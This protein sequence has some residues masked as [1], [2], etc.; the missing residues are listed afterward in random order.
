MACGFK[1][2]HRYETE[3]EHSFYVVYADAAQFRGLNRLLSMSR[4][5]AFRDMLVYKAAAA[6]RVLILVPSAFT[7]QACSSCGYTDAGNRDSQTVY[8]CL[9]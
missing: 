6:G 5:G 4:L 2:H 1:S 9:K 8:H 3:L 7:S